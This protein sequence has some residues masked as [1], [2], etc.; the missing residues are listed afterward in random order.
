[1]KTPILLCMILFLTG[2]AL[3]TSK[4]IK[5]AEELIQRFECN[6]IDSDQLSHNS[7]TGF[8]ER[9]LAVSKDKSI[10]YIDRYKSGEIL[11]DLPLYD[12]IQMQY[13]SYK[14]ACDFLG[15]VGISEPHVATP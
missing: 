8:H 4:E 13:T 7:I 11:F 1:M 2:C 14:S 10:E 5:R 9:T 3:G 6:N 15:G 12:I